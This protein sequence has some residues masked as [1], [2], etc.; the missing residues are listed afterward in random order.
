MRK[1]TL[2]SILLI[3]FSHV[4]CAQ[5]PDAHSIASLDFNVSSAG[6][7][8]VRVNAGETNPNGPP[9]QVLTIW[10]QGKRLLSYPTQDALVDLFLNY[11]DDDRVFAR[12]EGGSHV[13]FTV[14][15]VSGNPSVETVVFDKQLEGA[16]DVVN[17]PDVLLVHNGKRWLG[18]QTASMPISTDVY[19]WTGERY[20][21]TESWKWKDAMRY[22]DRFCVLDPKNLS[23]PVTPIPIK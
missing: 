4:L 20:A 22:E 14:F 9:T 12:W 18:G 23:C 16:P 2:V 11:P 8:S 21:L 7:C 19:R 13:R 3:M 15:R 1:R 17:T 10:C 5:E 6:D